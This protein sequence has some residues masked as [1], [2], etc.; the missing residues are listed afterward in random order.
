MAEMQNPLDRLCFSPA[1]NPTVFPLA[2]SAVSSFFQLSSAMQ[3]AAT[4]MA[5]EG[6]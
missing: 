3:P 6:W 1:L 4:A 5:A 2:W